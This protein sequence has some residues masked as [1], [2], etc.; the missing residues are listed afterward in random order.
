MSKLT[1]QNLVLERDHP[2]GLGGIQRIYRF[3]TGY[4]LSLIN[5]SVFRSRPF[6][7]E[8]AVLMDVSVDGTKFVLTYDTELTDD[9]EVFNSDEEANTFIERA[10]RLFNKGK[11]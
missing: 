7:W 8:A 9:V 4:G 2:S 6:A 5:G 11:K 10:E 1:K 3:D